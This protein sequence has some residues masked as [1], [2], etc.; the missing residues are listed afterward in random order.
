[1][2]VQLKLRWK[3]INVNRN[4]TANVAIH[5]SHAVIHNNKTA[6]CMR[7]D[8]LLVATPSE[9]DPKQMDAARELVFK[10]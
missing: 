3:V 1:M 9:S 2:E 7:T 5:I 10:I 8:R 4:V 6:M